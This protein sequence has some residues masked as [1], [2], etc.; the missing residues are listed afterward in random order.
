MER[1]YHLFHLLD[2]K[3]ENRLWYFLE[4]EAIGQSPAMGSMCPTRLAKRYTAE[5]LITISSRLLNWKDISLKFCESI[6]LFTTILVCSSVDSRLENFSSKF[7]GACVV[8]AV[9]LHWSRS[10]SLLSG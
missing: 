9:T 10:L 3:S 4:F 5:S 1:T 7:S 2:T 8:T 6:I